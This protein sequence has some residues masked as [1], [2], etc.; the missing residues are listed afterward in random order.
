MVNKEILAYGV[1]RTCK[2]YIVLNIQQ[3]MHLAL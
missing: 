2:L 1:K 3:Y